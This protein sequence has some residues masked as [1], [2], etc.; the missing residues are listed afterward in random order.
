MQTA[1][2]FL[3]S[4]EQHTLHDDSLK[5]LREVGAFFHSDRA[6]DILAKNGA[7]VDKDSKIARIPEE[8]VAQ[9]TFLSARTFARS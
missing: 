9:A 2:Q 8:M 6:L 4:E 3:S 1:S 5:I 7:D